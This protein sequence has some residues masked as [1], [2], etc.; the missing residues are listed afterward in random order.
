MTLTVAREKQRIRGLPALLRTYLKGEAAVVNEDIAYLE[1]LQ[2]HLHHGAASAQHGRY[3]YRLRAAA[4]AYLDLLG[5][6]PVL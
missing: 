4:E 3:E 5:S 1:A 2:S 6:E